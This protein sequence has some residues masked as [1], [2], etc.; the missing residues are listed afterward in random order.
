MQVVQLLKMWS[1]FDSSSSSSGGT[2]FGSMKKKRRPEISEP[3]NFEH[4]VHTGFDHDQGKFVGLPPQW[5]SV[6]NPSGGSRPA[7]IV[8]PSFVTPMEMQMAKSYVRLYS[9]LRALQA[10]VVL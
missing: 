10:F 7:P 8:D 4:R 3:T 1:C 2:M 9:I 5:Q 6:V